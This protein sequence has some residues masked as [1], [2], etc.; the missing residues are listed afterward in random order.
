MTKQR[1]RG[2]IRFIVSIRTFLIHFGS[3]K[4]NC[5]VYYLCAESSASS[6]ASEFSEP[7]ELA[8]FFIG[9]HTAVQ[10]QRNLHYHDSHS[11]TNVTKVSPNC[12]ESSV[13]AGTNPSIV[14]LPSSKTPFSTLRKTRTGIDPR[15]LSSNWALTLSSLSRYRN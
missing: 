11:R 5:H 14:Y 2:T 10:S 6:E 3:F 13:P 7:S 8:Q 12:S 4:W 15:Q 9:A 1:A